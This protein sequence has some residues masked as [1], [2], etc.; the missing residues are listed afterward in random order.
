SSTKWSRCSPPPRPGRSILTI[1]RENW[2]MMKTILIISRKNRP[3]AKNILIISRKNP[4]KPPPKTSGGNPNDQ[5]PLAFRRYYLYHL[6]STPLG[7][8]GT[9]GASGVFPNDDYSGYQKQNLVILAC[10]SP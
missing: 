3:P 10:T 6:H 4:Q 8:D 9:S 5:L 1:S 2:G 7:W